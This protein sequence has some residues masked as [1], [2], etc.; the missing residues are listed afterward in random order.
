MQNDLKIIKH[1]DMYDYNHEV[2]KMKSSLLFII[3]VLSWRPGKQLWAPIFSFKETRKLSHYP[4]K[5]RSQDV[6]VQIRINLLS[7]KQ[8]FVVW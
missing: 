8:K 1:T 2:S 7:A 4:P 5:L 6:T 3:S